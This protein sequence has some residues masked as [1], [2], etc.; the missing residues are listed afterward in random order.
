MNSKPHLHHGG[1]SVQGLPP[2]HSTKGAVVLCPDLLDDLIHGPAIQLLV[3]HHLQRNL[4]L[5]LIALDCLQ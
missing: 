5:L 1:A 4:V 3:G 2:E